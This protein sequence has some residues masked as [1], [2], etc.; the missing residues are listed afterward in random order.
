MLRGSTG[1][2]GTGTSR[3]GRPG[4]RSTRQVRRGCPRGHP[5]TPRRC[6]VRPRWS[7][8]RPPSCDGRDGD[9][10]DP[11]CRPA[12][13]ERLGSSPELT[14]A[15]PH[16]SGDT[17]HPSVRAGRRELRGPP[18]SKSGFCAAPPGSRTGQPQPVPAEWRTSR[19][20]K[21]GSTDRGTISATQRDGSV[22]RAALLS[23]DQH[24]AAAATGRR[25]QPD[26]DRPG[27]LDGLRGARPLRRG[28]RPGVVEV[29]LPHDGEGGTIRTGCRPGRRARRAVPTRDWPRRRARRRHP[30][31]MAHGLDDLVGGIG[32]SRSGLLVRRLGWSVQRRVTDGR[33]VSAARPTR[34]RTS[35]DWQ[36]DRPGGSPHRLPPS[37]P[38]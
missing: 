38:T 15:C 7:P 8:S 13:A 36:V 27:P 35:N 23:G 34:R 19:T 33:A 26:L 16:H 32:A 11:R 30:A 25:R 3:G 10:L 20:N 18:L 12:R 1:P 17:D 21:R 37:N 9:R 14:R 6:R 2:R 24:L 28:G 22:G 31:P 4:C 5:R 29:G